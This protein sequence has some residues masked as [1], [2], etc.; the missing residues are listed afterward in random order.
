MPLA[1]SYVVFTLIFQ[2]YFL[3]APSP[4]F[5]IYWCP[6]NARSSYYRLSF[7]FALSHSLCLAFSLCLF[8]RSFVLSGSCLL[9]LSV[10]RSLVCCLSLAASHIPLSP[11]VALSHLCCPVA[12]SVTHSRSLCISSSSLALALPRSVSLAVSHAGCLSLIFAIM[13]FRALS[14]C[15]LLSSPSVSFSLALSRPL[16]LY[17]SFSYARS[18]AQCLVLSPSLST[19]FSPSVCLPSLT[20]RATCHV[21]R[22]TCQVKAQFCLVLKK[23]GRWKTLFGAHSLHL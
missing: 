5:L 20:L 8:S 23:G 19:S 11:S 22:A 16:T 7:A 14:Q 10:S 12:L 6:V 17:R 13:L 21:P 4:F 1:N 9:A 2:Y 3:L 18:R 15:L